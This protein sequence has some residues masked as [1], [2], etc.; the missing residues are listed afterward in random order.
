M[1]LLNLFL[2]FK[3]KKNSFHWINLIN[4]RF[5]LGT[6][7]GLASSNPAIEL[8]LL[9]K[10]TKK[11]K[12][13]NQTLTSIYFCLIFIHSNKMIFGANAKIMFHIFICKFNKNKKQKWREKKKKAFKI[14]TKDFASSFSIRRYFFFLS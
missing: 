4:L 2:F 14:K 10:P 12:K 7:S 1:S 5:I 13:S 8:K 3:K 9:M 11:Q 6:F